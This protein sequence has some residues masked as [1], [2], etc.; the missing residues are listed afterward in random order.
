M[1]LCIHTI[2]CIINSLTTGSKSN[3]YICYNAASCLCKN[4]HPIHAKKK[5]YLSVFK[6]VFLELACLWQTKIFGIEYFL[7]PVVSSK[8]PASKYPNDKSISNTLW[9][10]AWGL[11]IR[12]TYYTNISF[13]Q[14]RELFPN[15]NDL[16]LLSQFL[17]SIII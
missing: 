17:F 4:H 8:T 2:M 16:I 15:N 12:H 3:S 13:K 7:L 14:Y 1:K 10:S 9:R 5:S 11:L 6:K